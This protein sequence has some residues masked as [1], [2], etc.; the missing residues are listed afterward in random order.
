MVNAIKPEAWLCGGSEFWH[1]CWG[2][3]LFG[4]HFYLVSMVNFLCDCYDGLLIFLCI[5]H[6]AKGSKR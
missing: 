1:D 3:G 2:T 5:Y 4:T 6:A